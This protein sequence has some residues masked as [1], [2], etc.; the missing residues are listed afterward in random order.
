MKKILIVDDEEN[1][2]EM[3]VHLMRTAGYDATSE[4]NGLLAERD[5]NFEHFDLVII[6]MVMPGKEGYLT[7]AELVRLHKDLKIIAM[8][9]GDKSFDGTTYLELAH[10]KGAHLTIAKPFTRQD[11]LKAVA[12]LLGS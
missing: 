7:V 3:L 5:C 1:I 4:C 6:D 8:S 2:R 10:N 11:I 12:D 9:G